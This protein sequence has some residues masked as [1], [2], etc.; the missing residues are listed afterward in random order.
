M[1]CYT[2]LHFRQLCSNKL[3]T[4][5]YILDKENNRQYIKTYFD[6]VEVNNTKIWRIKSKYKKF[7]RVYILNKQHWLNALNINFVNHNL[8]NKYWCIPN[9]NYNFLNVFYFFS[10]ILN[11]FATL[12]LPLFNFNINFIY[13]NYNSLINPNK[14]LTQFEFVKF[15]IT[16]DVKCIEIKIEMT[17]MITITFNQLKAANWPTN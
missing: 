13:K 12:N 7:R 3:F 14:D 10:W 2:Y 9:T 11:I 1:T 6:T 5:H 8:I 15:V 4:L 17:I 16:Y